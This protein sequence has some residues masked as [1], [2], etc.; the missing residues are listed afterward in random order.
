M[1]RQGV[2]VEPYQRS[3][4]KGKD[5]VDETLLRARERMEEVLSLSPCHIHRATIDQVFLHVPGL[6]TR[7]KNY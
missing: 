3:S 5:M 4:F 7:L 2:L 6:L 1:A